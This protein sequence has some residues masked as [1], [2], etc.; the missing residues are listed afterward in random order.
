[1]ARHL[2]A[3]LRD[4]SGICGRRNSAGEGVY[5]VNFTKQ[6]FF[7]NYIGSLQLRDAPKFSIEFEFCALNLRNWASVTL[8][9]SREVQFFMKFLVPMAGFCTVI[10]KT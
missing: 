9:L 2:T 3:R 5:N 6:S 4:V 1:M 8:N 10:F 7:G